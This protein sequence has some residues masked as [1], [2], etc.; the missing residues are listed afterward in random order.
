MG[1]PSLTT[2]KVYIPAN[3]AQATVNG[4][5]IVFKIKT[6]GTTSDIVAVSAVNMSG[7][8]PTTQGIHKITIKASSNQV[9]IT[10]N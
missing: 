2:L 1:E 4:R 6:K 3:L 7:S 5:E 10:S 9:N 8:L